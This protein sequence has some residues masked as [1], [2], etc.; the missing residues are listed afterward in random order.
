MKNLISIL[1]AGI[2]LALF[3]SCE[4]ETITETITE[5]DTVTIDLKRG[6][7]AYY[8]L[9]G[10]TGDSS[11]NGKHGTAF[12][13]LT[14]ST[15]VKNQPDSAANFDGVDDYINIEDATNYFAPPKMSVSFLFN[16]RDVNKR[17]AMFSKSALATPTAVAWSAGIPFANDPYFT[18]SNGGGDNP[19]ATVWGTGISYSQ[20]YNIALQN[21]RWYHATLIFNMGVQMIYI[22]GQL[23]SAMVGSSP[24]QNQCSGAN[25]RMGAWWASD[26]VSISG[27]LDEV[28][29]YNRILAENEIEKLAEERN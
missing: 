5:T 27:K 16:L 3:P 28:R 9:N 23:V 22:N 19:C 12:N 17:A 15:N 4:K 8:Q 1:M 18:F 11:G 26:L 14:Y 6:L 2:C 21:N 10:N 24:Y 7:I 25:L 20:E 29:I 13:G